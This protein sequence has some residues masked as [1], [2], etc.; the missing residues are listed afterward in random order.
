[1]DNKSLKKHLENY[2][3]WSLDY[4]FNIVKHPIILIECIKSISGIDL[5][6]EKPNLIEFLDSFIEEKKNHKIQKYVKFENQKIELPE[7]VSL[8]NLEKH[9]VDLNIVEAKQS[10]SNLI[11]VSDGTQILEYLLELSIKYSNYNTSVFIWSV[12]KME[13][14]L[15]NKYLSKSIY[16]CL[17]HIINNFNPPKISENLQVDWSVVFKNSCEPFEKLSFYY[18]LYNED[19]VRSN[20]IK[21]QMLL[22]DVFSFK[23]KLKYNK[24]V[25][26]KQCMQGRDWILDY[27]QGHKMSYELIICLDSLRSCLK[28]NH[29]NNDIYWSRFNERLNAFN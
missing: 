29:I 3:A 11:K 10:I 7:V 15:N 17:E 12:Y 13:K 26:D 14:F 1:M 28:T 5:E 16:I 24:S 2:Y 27:I 6:K 25:K 19:M 20:K 9:I 8:K 21:H 22:L 23:N 4:D 18:K